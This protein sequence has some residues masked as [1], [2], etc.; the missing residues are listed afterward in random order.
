MKYKVTEEYDDAPENPIR[1]VKGE[2]L[3]FIEESDPDGN[4]PNWIFCRGNRKEG[5]VPKQILDIKGKK[6]VSLENYTAR[7]HNLIKGEILTAVKELNGWIWS[8]K[9]SEPESPGWAPLNHLQKL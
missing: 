5:W 6:A 4:W 2:V 9:E 3:D 8:W 1:I 7:E